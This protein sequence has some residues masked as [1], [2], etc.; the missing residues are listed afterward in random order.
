MAKLTAIIRLILFGATSSAS[1][2]EDPEPAEFVPTY[3]IL[4]F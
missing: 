2:S 1:G 3:H 4:G